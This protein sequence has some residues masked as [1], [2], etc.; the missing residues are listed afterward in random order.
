MTA[1]TQTSGTFDAGALEAAMAELSPDV[2]PGLSA[3]VVLRGSEPWL[4]SVGFAD[5]RL[6]RRASN[7]TAYC[8]FSMTKLVTATVAM[9][10]TERGQL[11]L[12]DPVRRYLPDFPFGRR[13][14][15]VTVRH[16]LSHSAGLSNPLPVRWIHLADEP[17]PPPGEL[18]SRLMRRQR[19]LKGRPGERARYSNVG[20]LVLGEVL[21][22]A[23]G[24]PFEELV[25]ER[26][27]RPIGMTRTDFGYTAAVAHDAATPYHWRRSLP[28]AAMELVL[29]RRVIGPRVGQYRQ[30]RRFVNDGAAY[31]GLIGPIHDAARFLTA[32]SNGGSLNETQ[33]VTANSVASMQTREA[34]GRQLDVGLGWFRR[35]SDPSNAERYLSTIL[36]QD[37]RDA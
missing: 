12:D 15:S 13:G 18:L 3:A 28:A 33:L 22:A 7:A 10:L 21:A 31:G 1:V 32:H 27:L 9:Q 34:E 20:F 30:L 26:V 11:S 2:V 36:F 25:R 5:L 17:A 8:W 14:A 4:H 24:Q 29:P 35:H 19:R 16:L 23:S 6:R 37:L